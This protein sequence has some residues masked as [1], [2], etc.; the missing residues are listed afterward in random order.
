MTP[1]MS[2]A[3]AQPS[4]D[5]FSIK[6]VR[7]LLDRWLDGRAIVVDPFA[8]NST[9]ATITNDLNPETS[10]QH[11]MHSTEFMQML[12]DTRGTEWVDAVLID[13]PYSP[14]QISE[15]YRDA[16]R[17]VTAT[18]TQNARLYKEC[19]DRAAILLKPGGV[20]I[21]CGWNSVG[22]GKSRGF[23]LDEVL[24]VSCG[25]AHNDYIVTV[26]TKPNAAY[27]EVA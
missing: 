24:L 14:R 13:P 26:D 18:D 2:R 8:R 6:P 12:I 20:A 1:A 15:C 16:G 23:V 5:T 17:K 11:H 3:T 7:S 21:C 19:K 9:I 25:G 27:M 22:M 4:P 10:A